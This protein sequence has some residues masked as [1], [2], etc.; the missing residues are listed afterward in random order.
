MAKRYQFRLQPVLKHRQRVEEQKQVELAEAQT[1]RRREETELAA[2]E[3]REDDAVER[4]EQQGLVGRLDV[5]LLRHGLTYLELLGKDITTQT[6]T[7]TEARQ[8]AE[9]KRQDTVRAQQDRRVLEKLKERGH[10]RWQLETGRAETRAL[11]E[12][13]VTRHVRKTD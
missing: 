4:L 10:R 9:Q 11:D 8:Q 13:A 12:M 2:L 5:E 1:R 3:A 6:A 7:V